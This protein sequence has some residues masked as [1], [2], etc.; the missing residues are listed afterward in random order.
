MWEI[1]DQCIMDEIISIFNKIYQ[2]PELFVKIGIDVGEN[3]IVQFGYEQ[4]SPID[5]LGYSMNITSKI[6]SITGANQVYIGENVYKSLDPVLQHEF[7]EILISD[8]RWKYVNYGTD[9]PY[10]VYTLNT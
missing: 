1:D 4:Q 3:A 5:I 8:D 9:K 2:Y 6:M 10:K 7:H